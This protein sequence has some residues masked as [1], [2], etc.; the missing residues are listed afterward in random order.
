MEVVAVPSIPKQSHLYTSADEVI[1][2]LLDL[3]PEKWGLPPFQDC[4]RLSTF[5]STML[6]QFYM[7]QPFL[8]ELLICIAGVE[9]T[10]PIESWYIG[11]P[12]IKGLKGTWDSHRYVKIPQNFLF[13]FFFFWMNERDFFCKRN[14]TFCTKAHGKQAAVKK[15]QKITRKLLGINIPSY[16][17]NATVL[18]FLINL[19]Y[20]RNHQSM[21]EY[22]LWSPST[23][24]HQFSPGCYRHLHIF[25]AKYCKQWLQKQVYMLAL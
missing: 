7:Y 16:F 1:N 22:H 15:Q 8:T 13:L 2:S 11:G 19:G 18:L 17:P 4:K 10:L 25:E 5:V 9:G 21:L 23:T 3:K 24:F 20:S 12:V 6:S 14:R